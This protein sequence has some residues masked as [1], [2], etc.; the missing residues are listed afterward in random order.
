MER[1]Y[2]A[3]THT[4]VVVDTKRAGRNLA[5]DIRLSALRRSALLGVLSTHNTR[6]VLDNM[7]KPCTQVY[8][9]DCMQWQSW[10][11]R[12][13]ALVTLVVHAQGYY[14]YFLVALNRIKENRR[15]AK[16]RRRPQNILHYL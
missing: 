15:L 4:L 8:F 13:C 5:R 14:I 7:V 16:V 6:S 10:A 3:A 12:A 9:A 1:R 2:I 11:W